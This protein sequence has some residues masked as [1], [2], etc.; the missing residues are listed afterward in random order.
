[1]VATGYWIEFY[2]PNPKIPQDFGILLTPNNI[3][4][5]LNRVD[6]DRENWVKNNLNEVNLG[7]KIYQ[8]VH[9]HN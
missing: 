3:T 9:S 2:R 7:R 5:Y 8:E 4:T 6:R 1:M